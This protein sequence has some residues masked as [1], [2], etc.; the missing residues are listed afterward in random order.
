MPRATADDTVLIVYTSGTTGFPKG[1]MHSQRSFVTG[2]E[3][4]VQRVHLQEHD[5]VMIVLPLFHI[6]AL[7]Y[8]VAGTLAAGC[9]MIVVPRFSAS[10]FWHTAADYG[11]TEVNIIEAVGTILKNRPRSEFRP[12][13]KL[14]VAYGVRHATEATFRDEFHIPHLI[15]G[16]GMTEIPGVT[17]NPLEGPRKPGSMGPIGR[18]PD[19]AR[20]WAQCRVVDEAGRDLGPKEEGELLVKTP[21]IMQGYFRDPEQTRDAFI[22]GWFRT[23]DIVR[24][25]EDGYFFFVSRKKDIIR[26]RGENISGAELDRVI[27]AHPAVHEAA[28][29]P[30]A[31]ELGEDEILVAIVPK[32]RASLAPE[33]IAEWCRRHLAPQKVPRYVLFLDELPHTPTHKVAKAVL[34]QD[35]TLKVRAADLQKKTE[36]E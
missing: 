18:H 35:A 11:A 10:T 30:V 33:D 22:D 4:F 19:P 23:G 3:A 5:R 28:A 31:S 26:R 14:R 32:P 13:H 27:G 7:F 8:S 34:R 6:N 17:C 25:D 9:S 29:I 24:R 2:G 15:G 36:E 16:Y 1:A 21:I 20:P 12:D